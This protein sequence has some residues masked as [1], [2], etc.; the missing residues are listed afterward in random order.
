MQDIV[1]K[2]LTLHKKLSFPLRVSLVNEN[3]ILCSVKNLKV[4]E[5]RL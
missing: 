4:A 1:S 3:F 5:S 2:H